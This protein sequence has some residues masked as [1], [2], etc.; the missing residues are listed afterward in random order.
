MNCGDDLILAQ[1]EATTFCYPSFGCSL[2]C[3]FDSWSLICADMDPLELLRAAGTQFA[4]A[5]ASAVSLQK[6]AS[7]AVILSSTLAFLY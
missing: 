1:I 6:D 7:Y 2:R 3:T 4:D 5:R